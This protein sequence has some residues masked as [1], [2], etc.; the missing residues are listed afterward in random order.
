VDERST[1]VRTGTLVRFDSVPEI[2]AFGRER[3]PTAEVTTANVDD[4]FVLRVRDAEVDFESL[5]VHFEGE[6]TYAVMFPAAH[7]EQTEE[8]VEVPTLLG[9]LWLRLRGRD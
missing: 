4:E 3:Y 1:R 7:G 2:L 8:P 5:I 9:R 6:R